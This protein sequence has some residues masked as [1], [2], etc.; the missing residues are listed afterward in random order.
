MQRSAE[1][2]EASTRCLHLASTAYG[3]HIGRASAVVADDSASNVAS[4]SLVGMMEAEGN[5]RYKLC[6]I[7][8]ASPTGSDRRHNRARSRSFEPSFLAAHKLVADASAG[9]SST[10]AD[11]PSI[12]TGHFECPVVGAAPTNWCDRG[13]DFVACAGT[14]AVRH[15]EVCISAGRLVPCSNS[16][17]VSRPVFAAVH[18]APIPAG[19]GGVLPV[20]GLR[21]LSETT[22]ESTVGATCSRPSTTATTAADAA[23]ADATAARGADAGSGAADAR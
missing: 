1:R 4:S 3:T 17:A 2:R 10:A 11:V 20:G 14:A 23:T 13:C 6:W 21:T 9:D 8:I 18:A 16:A 15:A 19:G 12:S 5:R 22:V 7:V